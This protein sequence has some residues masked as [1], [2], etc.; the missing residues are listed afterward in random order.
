M[1][2]ERHG[3]VGTGH[4][5]EL[6][7]GTSPLGAA[8]SIGR[9]LLLCAVFAAMPAL[10]RAGEGPVRVE[11]VP[12]GGGWRLLRGG[13]PYVVRGAGGD[14]S[15]ELLAASGANSIRT[16]GADSLG[17]LLDRAHRLGLTVTVGFWLGHERHGF[18]YANRE[19]V[20]AQYERVREGIL[21]YKDHPAVLA[22]ALGNEMEGFADGGNPAIWAAVESL[23]ALAHRLDHEHPTMTVTADI[24]GKRVDA[25]HRLCPDIDIMGI[26]SY[27]GASSLPERYRR[28][29][30]TKP[31][32]VTE[33]GPPGTWEIGRNAWGAVE[34][35]SST[36]KARF[37]RDTYARLAADSAACLGSY[38]FAWGAKQ[39]ATATWYGMLL[40][41]GTRLAAADA[42]AELWSGRALA[43]HCPVI[44]SLTLAASGEVEPGA[45]VR[46]KLAA[47]DPEGDA[48]TVEWAL[49]ADP[50]SYETGGDQRPAPRRYRESIMNAGLSGAELRMPRRPGKYRV[51]VVVRDDKG[52]AAVANLPLHAKGAPGSEPIAD[53]VDLPFV[54]VGDSAAA[55]YAPSGWMG[56]F[57]S[58]TM[59]ASSREQPRSGATCMKFTYGRLEGWTG[60]VWQDPPN[61]WG[62]RAGGFELSGATRLT[63][64]VRGAIG[65]E[66]IKFGFGIIP[67]DKA[68]YDTA[69]A[70]REVTLTPEWRRVEISLKGK[71]LRRI[72]SGFWWT[73][74]G[75]GAPVTFFLDDVR[76][77]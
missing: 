55:A 47:N 7:C 57:G 52:G 10:A 32:V 40:P 66:R 51:S 46:V 45:A 60:V 50:T 31:Y 42:M 15:L 33:Y 27:G 36:R 75:Q 5:A 59:D 61:D 62:D 43:N 4:M 44:D 70:E 3:A 58:L 18:D 8:R 76:Y 34:E 67:K 22:W 12:Q 1:R 64:W 56:D 14:G 35:W 39:E 6:P 37:Y 54:V 73:L 65:G 49:R 48:L 53:A 29:G 21:R 11:I 30:G 41:D 68:F 9:A 20:A 74:G 71:P 19:Q 16:W 24:G 69:T 2:K 26:N 77:E 25:V 72:K 13:K 17:P 63:F 28:A 38:A 23:A